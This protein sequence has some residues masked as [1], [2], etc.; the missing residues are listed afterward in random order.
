LTVVSIISV[1]KVANGARIKKRAM[2][3]CRVEYLDVVK[4][5]LGPDRGAVKENLDSV[6]MHT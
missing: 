3:A 5:H 6:K 1:A 2:A 4:M